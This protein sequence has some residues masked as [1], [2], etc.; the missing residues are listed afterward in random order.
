MKDAKNNRPTRKEREKKR[1]RKEDMEE[2]LM[3]AKL[4][5]LPKDKLDYVPVPEY[6]KDPN[7]KP[8]K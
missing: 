8:L 6:L 5:M 4:T 1:K 3:K 7:R 2:S